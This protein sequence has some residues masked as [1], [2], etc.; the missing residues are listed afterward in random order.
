MTDGLINC[1]IPDEVV[2]IRITALGGV[3]GDAR[4]CGGAPCNFI[5]FPAVFGGLSGRVEAEL[6]V[7]GGE[8]FTVWLGYHGLSDEEGGTGGQ[9]N[10]PDL[11]TGSVVAPPL[12]SVFGGDGSCAS[13]F[14][15]DDGFFPSG[16]GGE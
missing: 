12:A 2:R 8:M 14:A 5:E 9:G 4:R 16:C 13:C 11:T 6:D 1:T 7:V 3:G 10:Y 15:N